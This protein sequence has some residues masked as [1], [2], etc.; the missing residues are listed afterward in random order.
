MVIATSTVQMPAP[1][2]ETTAIASGVSPGDVVVVDG[3]DK[4]KEG[5]KVE[6]TTREAQAAPA[7]KG[8]QQRGD[9][10]GGAK[11]TSEAS[12]GAPPKGDGQQPSASPSKGNGQRRAKDG[13]G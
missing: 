9:K 2:S 5:A 10:S 12:P 8:R 7:A 6:L 4:L 3:A 1:D 13:G 11:G